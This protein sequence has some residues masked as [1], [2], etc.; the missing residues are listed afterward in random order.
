M[1]VGHRAWTL[2]AA[3][4]HPPPTNR[5]SKPTSMGVVETARVATLPYAWRAFCLGM[6]KLRRAA[7]GP[8]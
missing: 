8:W 5:G 1:G 3:R 2:T 7:E 6:G 4:I